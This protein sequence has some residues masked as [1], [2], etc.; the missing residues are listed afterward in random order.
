MYKQSLNKFGVPLPTGGSVVM[1]QPKPKNK[2]RVIT[3]GFGSDVSWGNSGSWMCISA[4]SCSRPKLTVETHEVHKFDTISRYTGKQI[5]GE[6]TLT[7]K[8]TVDNKAATAIHSHIQKQKDYYR[9]I[10]PRMTGYGYKFEMMIQTMKGD[11]SIDDQIMVGGELI[12]KYILG[13][14]SNISPK[15]ISGTF[16]TW[17]CTGCIVTN[18][19]FGTYDYSTGNFNEIT[20]TI[21]PDN[22]ILL[23][24]G[25]NVMLESSASGGFSMGGYLS[26]LLGIADSKLGSMLGLS[27]PVSSTMQS[28]VK[29]GINSA[30]NSVKG[31]F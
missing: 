18:Y 11:V 20:L 27:G 10:A 9:R 8:D 22:C 26:G 1:S 30:F 6:M 23:D 16:E 25:G 17:L 31:W 4:N 3:Y 29:S 21:V 14:E 19:D 15:L 5:W 13:N 2:F 24:E 12:D 28:A 7:V